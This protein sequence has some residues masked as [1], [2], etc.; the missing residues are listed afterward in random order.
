MKLSGG[1]RNSAIGPVVL[2]WCAVIDVRK[3]DISVKII[4]YI[5]LRVATC[6]SLLSRD[7]M[8]YCMLVATFL[9]KIL[10]QF[11]GRNYLYTMKKEKVFFS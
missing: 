10:P 11:L 7:L 9:I 6:C 2:K 3:C 4:L 8:Y 1:S 5:L